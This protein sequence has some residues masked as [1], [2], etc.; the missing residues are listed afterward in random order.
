VKTLRAIAPALL[1]LLLVAAWRTYDPLAIDARLRDAV[2]DAYQ[3]LAP[4]PYEPAPVRIV[5]IDDE[6]LARGGLQWPWPRF[7]VARM[8][9]AL[10]DA[11]AASIAFDVV[12]AEPDRTS[13]GRVLEVWRRIGDVDDLAPA[14]AAAIDGLPDHDR[15]LAETIAAAGNVVV[16][17]ALVDEETGVAPAGRPGFAVAG[18]DPLPHLPAYPGALVNL[19]VLER[20]AAGHGSISF[21]PGA[22]LVVRSVPLVARH[23]DTLRPSLAAEAVRVAQGASTIVIRAAGASGD[24]FLGGMAGVREV[25]IG[26]AAVPTTPRGE[27]LVH[28]TEAVPERYLPAWRVLEGDFDPALVDGHVVL[29]G[30]SATGLRDIRPSP[31]NPAMPGVEA[32]ANAVEQMILGH[33]LIRPEWAEGAERAFLV[34]LGLVLAVLATTSGA[35]A[36]AALAALAVGGAVAASW[37]AYADRLLLVDPVG[38]SAAALA[39]YLA[40]SL[41]HHRREE[42][43]RLEIRGAFGRYLAPALVDRLAENPEMLRLASERRT[44][45]VMFADVRG[46]T[47]ISERFSDDPEGLIELINR[48]L[49][50]ATDAILGRRGTID[51]YMGD[52]VMAFW[53]APLDDADHAANACAA[54]V[55]MM[56]ALDRLNAELGDAA[57]AAGRGW[58]PLRIGIGLNTG[59]CVVGNMGSQQRFDYSALGDPVNLASRLESLSKLYGVPMLAGDA[60]RAAAPG[61]AWVEA[62]RVAVKGKT[63]PVRVWALMGGRELAADPG[64]RAAAAE[65]AA[66]LDAYRRRGWERADAGFREAAR[67][68]GGPLDGLRDLYAG[69]IAGFRERPPADDWDGTF[70]VHA[71]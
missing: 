57:A 32:H 33:H 36:G 71:K 45:T 3:A 21:S 13:P 25:R 49:T 27:M 34:V 23:G 18:E 5:D 68:A 20:A 7:E 24:L 70:V 47:G 51:K 6:T 4:R 67:L 30:A 17:F 31:L 41:V 59:P 46:F 16:G 62:D 39:V 55:D 14:L 60:T 61:F 44:I 58:A 38:P 22:D 28:Y 2:F 56:A 29:I 40:G 53:N 69:R 54:A 65:A 35:L 50:P 26:G 8:V 63:R 48:V 12:F 10:A 66:A 1:V 9:A 37:W 15:I 19:A 43:R 42:R 64:F 11:G 52:A